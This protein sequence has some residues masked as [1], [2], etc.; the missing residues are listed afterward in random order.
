MF[1]T[2][3]SIKDLEAR[4]K[5]RGTETL[6]KIKIRLENAVGELAFSKVPGNFDSIVENRDLD[7][8]FND[9]VSTLQSWYPELDLHLG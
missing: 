7:Q 1:I 2:P 4:L 6:E 5:G 8:A 9:V 3:P